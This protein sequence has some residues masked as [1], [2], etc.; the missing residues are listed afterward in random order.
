MAP[1]PHPSLVRHGYGPA[2]RALHWLTALAVLAALGLGLWMTRL[3]AGTEAEVARVFR[4]YSVHKTLGTILFALGLLRLLWWLADPG[5]GP[6]H[7]ERRVEA[8]AA[9]LTHW[10]LRLGLVALP[11]TGLLHHSAAPGLAPILWP[12]GQTLPGIPADERLALIFRAAH[13]AAGWLLMAALALHILGTLKHALVDRDATLA[14][15]VGGN[16]PAAG[17]APPALPAVLTAIALWTAVLSLAA[18]TAPEPEVLLPGPDILEDFD[19]IAPEEVF[20][21]PE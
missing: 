19:T 10:T 16:G 4:T 18:L 7:P 17:P 1:I 5:P 9:R 15:M 13:Q 8:F 12:V 11:V 20:T 14:R 6:L 21:P 3:P 2:A